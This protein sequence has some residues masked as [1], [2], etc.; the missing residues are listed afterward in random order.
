MKMTLDCDG[1]L[2]DIKIVGEGQD[3]VIIGSSD[4][5]AK[6]FSTDLYTK[7]RLIFVDHRGFGASTRDFTNN[8]FELDKIVSD[9]EF[10]RRSLK[11]EKFVL[12]GHSG[13]G[14]MVLAYAQKYPDHVSKLVLMN[15]SPY[16]GPKNFEAANK[17]FQ[18]SVCPE[19]KLLL[20][21]NLVTL[22]AKV[23]AYPARAFIARM[24]VFGPMIWFKPDYDATWLWENV[25]IVPEM[26]DYVWGK[27]FA[28]IDIKNY[29]SHLSMPVLLVLGRY[30]YWNPPYLWESY[31]ILF[32]DLT[33]R[34]FEQ[35]GHS[36]QLEEQS[37]FNRELVNF[38]K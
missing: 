23:A 24:L 4:Y 34:I 21:Q 2:L 22:E 13:H 18:E 15:L 16:G 7:L 26:I 10:V 32:K 37:E 38:I 8:D 5:Y 11:L 35:S 1:F 12:V 20:S 28:E 3:V 19:R 33:I 29:V 25:K 17:Y 30:D 31:R 14:Y 6:T 27:I 36:P 9:L